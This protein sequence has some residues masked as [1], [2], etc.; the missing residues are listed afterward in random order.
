[1]SQQGVK[2]ARFLG[3]LKD[4]LAAASRDDTQ[5]DA[6]SADTAP[7]TVKADAAMLRQVQPQNAAPASGSGTPATAAATTPSPSGGKDETRAAQNPSAAPAAV[8]APAGSG[9]SAAEAARAVKAQTS[10]KAD[11]HV[12]FA[13]PPTTRVVR[14]GAPKVDE[15]EATQP[16]R[17]QL[18]RGKAQVQR[19]EFEQD[20]VVGWLVVVGGA[21][22]G[23]FRPIFEGNNTMGRARNQ[24]IPLDFGD[25]AISSEEQA[26]I[27]YDSSSRSFLF[28]PNPAKT[29]IVSIN[30]QRPTGA[31]ELNQM[32]VITIGRTQPRFR[33]VL[34]R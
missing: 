20:P 6:S 3:S 31:V 27:R 2:P 13:T 18:V 22:M 24:R 25:D 1:M 33:A 23:A 10:L 9:P 34:W 32:D 8:A 4:A 29:N 5:R 21:G 16:P 19:G 7:V 26:Y 12:E 28:V 11:R 15:A 30:E 14:G 17:T